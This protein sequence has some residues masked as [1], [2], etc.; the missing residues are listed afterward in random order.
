MGHCARSS[1]RSWPTLLHITDSCQISV[2]ST[3]TSTCGYVPT[4]ANVRALPLGY[5]PSTLLFWTGLSLSLEFPDEVTVTEQ[6]APKLP[7]VF[8]LPPAL[9][10][11]STQ[12]LHDAEDLDSRLPACVATTLFMGTFPS[13]LLQGLLWRLY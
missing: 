3:D 13:L 1:R 11:C 12:L 7:P 9:A 10:C 6:Q 8:A 2:H 4:E 5:A